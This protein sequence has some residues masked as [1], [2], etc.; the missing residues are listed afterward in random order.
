MD[1]RTIIHVELERVGAEDAFVS[2]RR[3]IWSI[4][5]KWST[6]RPLQEIG[7]SCWIFTMV[8]TSW[9]VVYHSLHLTKVVPLA[10][11]LTAWEWAFVGLKMQEESEEAARRLILSV[12]PWRRRRTS[13]RTKRKANCPWVTAVQAWAHHQTRLCQALSTATWNTFDTRKL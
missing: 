11:S 8:P 12:V 9:R 4:R 5:W 2:D 3:Q 1:A 10:A 13:P 7:Q 6:V